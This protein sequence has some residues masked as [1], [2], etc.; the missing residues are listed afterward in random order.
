MFFILSKILS[1]MSSPLSWVFILFLWT[2][3][4]K[5]TSRRKKL[6][7]ATL[8][9]FYFFSNA[10][11]VDEF[12]RAYEQ[13]DQATIDK[14]EQYDIVIVLGGFMTWRIGKYCPTGRQRSRTHAQVFIENWGGQR[15]F[16]L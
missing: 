5:S 10:F 15:K 8:I 7:V 12:F 3:K 4:T 13:R 6:F 1:F 2:L 9:T 14:E 11:I 16:S